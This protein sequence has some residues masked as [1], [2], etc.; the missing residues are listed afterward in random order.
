MP[1]NIIGLHLLQGPQE[2]DAGSYGDL[3]PPNREATL[4]RF[5]EFEADWGARYPNNKSSPTASG[6]GS[7]AGLSTV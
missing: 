7:A 1:N 3:P 5:D 2:G 4:A 6:D